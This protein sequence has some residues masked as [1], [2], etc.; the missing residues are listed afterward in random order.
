MVLTQRDVTNQRKKKYKVGRTH[1]GDVSMNLKV[2]EKY[3]EHMRKKKSTSQ[4]P[5]CVLVVHQT[6][7]PKTRNI[8]QNWQRSIFKRPM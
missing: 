5:K 2:G 1:F 8:F 6:L 4:Q 3:E 7:E